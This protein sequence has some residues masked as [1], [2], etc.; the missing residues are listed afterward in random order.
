MRKNKRK[1]SLA[2]LMTMNIPTAPAPVSKP[3]ETLASFTKSENDR[4]A[5]EQAAEQKR[6]DAEKEAARRKADAP[7]VALQNEYQDGLRQLRKIQRENLDK[8]SSELVERCPKS[9]HTCE[10]A[11]EYSESMLAALRSGTAGVTLSKSESETLLKVAGANRTEIN[12]TNAAVWKEVYRYCV[13]LGVVGTS[14]TPQPA[15][16]PVVP[17]TPQESFD[18]MLDRLSTESREGRAVL[19]D[20]AA[21]ENFKAA[22]PMFR[23]WREHLH[24]DYNG[25]VPSDEDVTF[26]LN[27]LFP[28]LNLSYTRGESYNIVRRWMVSQGRW[29]SSML[30]DDERLSRE[31]EGTSYSSDYNTTRE[32]KRR[33]QDVRGAN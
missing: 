6:I 33:L 15:P 3:R 21:A 19:V 13:D 32:V 8:P 22:T 11:Q 29:A 5:K 12:L 14:P 20:A 24:R 30:T 31:M 23:E 1:Y 10:T 17:P 27:T 18:S 28:K 26:I 25:F 2:D 7:I 4:I 9:E 16:Q